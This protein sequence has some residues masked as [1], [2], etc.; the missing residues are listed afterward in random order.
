MTGAPCEKDTL[1]ELDFPV[2]GTGGKIGDD[3]SVR[4]LGTGEAR[5][6]HAARIYGIGDED[7]T[8][9]TI[10]RWT[11]CGRGKGKRRQ[12]RAAV[13]GLIRGDGASDRIDGQLAA[14]Q[15]R[16]QFI[17]G[18]RGEILCDIHVNLHTSVRYVRNIKFCAS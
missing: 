15:Q 12:R 5:C 9:H 11:K 4:L 17:Q 6:A 7:G 18:T 8:F 1:A 10:R 13:D 2:A 14:I 3:C 16:L